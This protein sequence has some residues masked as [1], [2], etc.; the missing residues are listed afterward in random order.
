MAKRIQQEETE[1]VARRVDARPVRKAVGQ[2]S[3]YSARRLHI[4]TLLNAGGRR[5]HPAP[6]DARRIKSS[7]ES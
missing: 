5:L 1:E 2:Q 4:P 6:G 7:S 3:H